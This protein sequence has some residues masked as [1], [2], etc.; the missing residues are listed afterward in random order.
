MP[1]IYGSLALTYSEQ[2][3]YKPSNLQDSALPPYL[4]VEIIVARLSL[5]LLAA[6]AVAIL[7]SYLAKLLVLP[8]RSKAGNI[9][10]IVKQ[11]SKCL[12]S[13]IEVVNADG[14]DPRH[15]YYRCSIPIS[16]KEVWQAWPS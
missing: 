10:N 8:S 9:S 5:Q 13:L 16:C 14:E 6:L 3:L 7:A 4:S 1:T 12:D 15:V 2:G 11:A